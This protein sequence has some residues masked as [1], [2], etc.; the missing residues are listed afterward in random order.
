MSTLLFLP[1]PEHRDALPFLPTAT[2]YHPEE[3]VTVYVDNV[4]RNRRKYGD[5][6]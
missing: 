4:A 2:S 3:G 1:A 5:A 6:S